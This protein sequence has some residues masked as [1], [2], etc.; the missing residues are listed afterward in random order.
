MTNQSFGSGYV[1]HFGSQTSRADASPSG[2]QFRYKRREEKRREEKRREENSTETKL[3]ELSI[4][5]IA[6][7]D[8]ERRRIAR[9][10]HDCTGQT[11]ALLK[12]NL[13]R[14]AKLVT[15][16]EPAGLLSESVALVQ[17]MS[18]QVRTISYLLHPPMLDEVGLVSALR[19][20]V[21][22]FSQR[23]G[24]Q[25]H[26]QIDDDFNRLPSEMEISIYRIVQECLTNIH[27][28][29]GSPTARIRLERH[30]AEIEIEVQDDGKGIPIE[31]NTNGAGVGLGGMRERA[32]QLGGTLKI[33]SNGKGTSVLTRLPFS[34]G[35][36]TAK[37]AT[38]SN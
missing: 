10:L 4:R 38:A 12:M 25:A 6:V 22:G 32:K 17:A 29:S 15:S 18:V 8:Q 16:P 19:G 28:H 27:R 1:E 37:G 11:I 23:S 5:L 7:Q 21:E 20:L 9:D 34:N 30:A 24:I 2:S 31:G 26:L 3:R 36:A 14:L 13:D 33:N 35:S